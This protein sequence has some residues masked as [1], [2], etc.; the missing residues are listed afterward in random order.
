MFNV[1]LKALREDRHLSQQDLANILRVKQSAVGNWESGTRVPNMETI[2]KLADFFDVSIDFLMGRTEKKEPAAGNGDKLNP[3]T[4]IFC[5]KNGEKR[6]LQYSEEQMRKLNYMLAS[7]K[8]ESPSEYEE[9]IDRINQ[10]SPSNRAKLSE[11]ID[12][13]LNAQDNKG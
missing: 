11:L 12:L 3:N 7:T 9:I 1:K 2:G 10:L 5:D 13:Y 8:A 6:V 4:V